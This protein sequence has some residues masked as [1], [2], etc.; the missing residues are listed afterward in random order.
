MQKR[1]RA[2]FIICRLLVN[3]LQCQRKKAIMFLTF[4]KLF[5]SKLMRDVIKRILVN[6]TKISCRFPARISIQRQ[7]VGA[8]LVIK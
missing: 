1:Y 4:V 6:V 5:D 8:A 7:A 2:L 3:A